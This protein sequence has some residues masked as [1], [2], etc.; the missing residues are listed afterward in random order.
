[1]TTA[2]S[3]QRLTLGLLAVVFGVYAASCQLAEALN[4]G[5][6]EAC[7][8]PFECDTDEGLVCAGNATCQEDGDAGTGIMGSPCDAH[9]D[10]RID[11]S[12]AL[13]C[14]VGGF[15]ATPGMVPETGGCDVTNHCV[16]PL[17]CS[18]IVEGALAGTCKKAGATGTALAGDGCKEFW[19]CAFGL[20]CGPA[21]TCDQLPFYRGRSCDVS[22]EDAGA[23][24]AL[25]EVPEPGE[26]L[27]EFY[28]A[29]FPADYRKT[30]DGFV[31]LS[32]HP[33]PGT[34]RTTDM[35]KAYME[36]VEAGAT[37]FSTTAAIYFR[38]SG[39]LDKATLTADGAEP[40]IRFVDVSGG[41]H[42]GEAVPFDLSYRPSKGK[43]ICSHRLAI[44]PVDA[45]PLRPATEYAVFVSKGVKGKDGSEV[46]RDGDFEEVMGTTKPGDSRLANAYDALGPLRGWLAQEGIDPG[47]LLTATVFTTA[48][49]Y[50]TS[51]G[52]KAAVDAA[53]SP[54]ASDVTLCGA[55]EP[56]P[57][58]GDGAGNDL[59][60]RAC[61][62]GERPF[63]EIHLRIK[64][65]VFQ[66][67]TA[68]YLLITTGGDIRFEG[69]AAEIQ[70]PEKVCAALTIPTGEAPT[71][72]WPII[73]YGH[74]T[75][76]NFRGFVNGRAGI[77]AEL[78]DP[79]DGNVKFAMLGFDQVQHGP[80][81][82]GTDLPAESLF[83][84]FLN[85]AAARD[86]TLQGAGDIFSLVRFIKEADLDV[87]G[88]GRV[89]FDANNIYY[90]GH[91][92]GTVTGPP[93]V[94]FE[95]SIKAVLMSG[96]GGNL[97]QSLLNKTQPVNIAD[98]IRLAL[99][100]DGVDPFHEILN[101]LQHHI[102][103]SDTIN[104]ARAFFL[105]PPDGVPPKH[106][107]HIY[108]RRDHYA[109]EPNQKALAQAMGAHL[110]GPAL[111][112][113][114]GIPHQAEGQLS[115]NVDLGGGVTV[116]GGVVEYEPVSCTE[117]E[118]AW[119]LQECERRKTERCSMLEGDKKTECEA[120]WDAAD[121]YDGHH[122]GSHAESEAA[123]PF[124]FTT[125]V[126]RGT[127]VI[128]R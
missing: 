44:R 29:P 16:P 99:A 76:G 104:Y 62:G 5:V 90:F 107:M 18:G 40:T 82:G 96:A 93:S 38:F 66:Y 108:G 36:A 61:G 17:I 97:V 32:G 55:G 71:D 20:L 45:Y 24:R 46:V 115:G 43:Y 72:G 113:I 114:P 100:D 106:V 69:D 28:R 63:H 13:Q 47:T 31:D 48:D 4:K 123:W 3:I 79:E 91:S 80:R 94:V 41:D 9:E 109:P 78:D 89:H 22:E 51:R 27:S 26:P 7:T 57:C 56:S 15:C 117:T 110:L 8:S 95:P 50:R 39:R 6:G 54:E 74:G 85:P 75:G 67:G 52:M 122:V 53:P 105:E 73:L 92:Q 111:A 118:D 12:G 11:I 30:T 121:A 84:N 127:P 42:R 23:L 64:M 58:A 49:I 98:G 101:V 59:P 120:R 119:E 34:G 102:A 116:S 83:F 14:H 128:K 112:E 68:P 77:V 103:P 87:G 65:P 35:S 1:M 21:K 88:V 125:A 33:E 70:R 126:T 124:F 37:G 81:R 2:T 86:N 19:D 10:C 25:F 60:E